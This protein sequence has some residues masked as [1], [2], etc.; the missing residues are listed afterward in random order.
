M[1][2]NPPREAFNLPLLDMPIM[3]YGLLFA[4]GFICGYFILIPILKLFLSKNNKPFSQLLVDKLTWYIVIGT[5]L[6]S[7]LGH[8]LFYDWPYYAANPS[9]IL[10]IRNGGLA[11]HG[12]VLGILMALLLFLHYNKKQFPELSM[13]VIL[14]ALVIPTCITATFIRLANFV[15]QEILGDETTMP[16]GVIFGD[17]VEGSKSIPRHPVQ[18]YEALSYLITFCILLFI[19]KIKAKNLKVGL[20]SGLFFILVF[21]AR[22]FIEFLKTPQTSWLDETSIQMGQLLSLPFIILGLILLSRKNKYIST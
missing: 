3:W 6:G 21:G 4:T 10:M 11:S 15:N 18:L 9:E 20:L 17:A 13:G 8:V 2:W 12:G 22:F 7:R 1:F 5:L 19:L 16:W 14:D